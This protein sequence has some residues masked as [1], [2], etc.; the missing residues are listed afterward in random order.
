VKL[1]LSTVEADDLF[2]IYLGGDVNLNSIGSVRF[3]AYSYP[4]SVPVRPNY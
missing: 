3:I 2:I 1:Q 4:D